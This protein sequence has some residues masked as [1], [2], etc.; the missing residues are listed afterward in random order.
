MTRSTEE[1]MVDVEAALERLVGGTRELFWDY[2]RRFHTAVGRVSDPDH[3]AVLTLLDECL[4]HRFDHETVR[5]A[6]E[7]VQALSAGWGGLR[8]GQ[9]LHTFE[10]AETPLLF[11]AWW[12]WDSGTT[13]SLRVGCLVADGPEAQQEMGK[14]IRYLFGA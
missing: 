8:S 4:P 14:R 3:L 11:T 9:L 13:F 2:D 7:S 5:S 10:P 6:P 1:V 12:P